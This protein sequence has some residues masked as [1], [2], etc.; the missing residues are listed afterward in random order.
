MS[1]EQHSHGVVV[2]SAF[3]P[4]LLLAASVLAWNG[5]QAY[6]LLMER[7]S[8]TSVIADQ[9]PRM[10]ASQKVRAA[11]ESLAT[12]TARIARA[13]NPN[14]TIVVEELRKRGITISPEG[15]AATAP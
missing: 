15:D 12:R 13:G 9:E 2:R 6:Q 5:F 8:L 11:L 14:A 4:A 1:D 7:N 10:E 3:L